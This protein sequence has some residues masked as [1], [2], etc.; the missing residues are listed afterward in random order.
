MPDD[1]PDL[2][3][4]I[5]L[6][7]DDEP[8]TLKT[9]TIILRRAGYSVWTAASGE[10]A[11]AKLQQPAVSIS[12]LLTD[13]IMSGISGPELAE[14]ALH[15]NSDLRILM[16]SAGTPDRLE[17]FRSAAGRFP[18][19]PKPLVA[20]VLLAAIRYTLSPRVQAVANHI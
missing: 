19:L 12:L 5:I 6:V 13:V 7:V 9:A 18:I 11:L 3:R 17:R 8:V 20:D 14:Q 1:G 15:E 10:E 2:G 16:M 4:P